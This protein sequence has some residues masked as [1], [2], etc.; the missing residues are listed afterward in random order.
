MDPAGILLSAKLWHH[1]V[2]PNRYGLMPIRYLLFVAPKN[3]PKWFGVVPYLWS[4]I[5]WQHPHN[6]VH[7][8]P[9]RVKT[10][11]HLRLHTSWQECAKW[12]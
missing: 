6:R 3:E 10:K 7:V 11:L 9:S 12:K 4:I 5:V 8:S 1:V 2:G